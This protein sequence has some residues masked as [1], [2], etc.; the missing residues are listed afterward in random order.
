M[1]GQGIE[2]R[3]VLRIFAVAAAAAKFPGFSRWTFACE[4]VGPS[5]QI[6]PAAYHPNFFSREEYAIIERLAEIMIPSDGTPGA[7]EA[8]VAEFIDFMVWND[9]S[10]QYKFRTGLTWLNAYAE[11]MQGKVFRQLAP[12]QQAGLLEVLAYK[13]KFRPGEE[14]GREFFRLMREYTVMGFY[15]TEVGLKELDCPALKFYGESPQC[16]HKDDPEHRHLPPPKW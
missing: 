7:H 2:R 1:A 13:E 11:R 5:V 15:T 16:P 8:G 3:E 12:E 9:A 4:H 6:R 14:Y 10:L